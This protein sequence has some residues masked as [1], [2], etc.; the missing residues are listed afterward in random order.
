MSDHMTLWDQVCKTDMAYTKKVNVRG[1][2]T[3][4]SPQWQKREATK[5]WGSYGATWGLKD[6][7]WSN[8]RTPD[9]VLTDVILDAVFWCPVCE[10][11]ISIDAPWQSGSECRKKMQTNAISKALSFLGFSADI[12]LGEL[13]HGKPARSTPLYTPPE[14][15]KK[16]LPPAPTLGFDEMM[17]RITAGE[18][19]HHGS[20]E[21]WGKAGML[22][23]IGMIVEK[24]VTEDQGKA[25]KATLK[26]VLDGL[27]PTED[28][29][30]FSG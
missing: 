27:Q 14:P 4:I 20:P 7:Q 29:Q 9:G 22:K 6:L 3:S 12:Y 16:P 18:W 13:D 21:N 28:E 10:F 5:I 24:E 19:R 11:P 30:P 26:E 8:L 25:L 2:F 17:A 23:I 15:P 1:G